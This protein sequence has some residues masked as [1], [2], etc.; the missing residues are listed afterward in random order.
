MFHIDD[1]QHLL[2]GLTVTFVFN[3][4]I[5]AAVTTT[6]ELYQIDEFRRKGFNLSEYWWGD[7]ATDVVWD[8]AGITLGVLARRQL[9]K[10]K[11]AKRTFSYCT[12]IPGYPGLYVCRQDSVGRG[13]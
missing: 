3:W 5:G 6:V 1:F 8:A 4:P 12:E 11:K 10:G 13:Q 2:L 9:F 7:A